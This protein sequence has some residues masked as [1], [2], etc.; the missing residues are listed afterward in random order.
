M[1][2]ILK[3]GSS[4]SCTLIMIAWHVRDSGYAHIVKKNFSDM[5]F[6]A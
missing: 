1:C 4:C 5:L 2:S 3:S 6:H